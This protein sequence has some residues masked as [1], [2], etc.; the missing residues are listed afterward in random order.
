MRYDRLVAGFLIVAVAAAWS[1]LLPGRV[2]V[3]SADLSA[4]YK[5]KYSV[6]DAGP[7]DQ[8]SISA[9]ENG[10]VEVL[11]PFISG[12]CI[13]INDLQVQSVELG[14]AGVQIVN[15]LWNS[16][17]GAPCKGFMPMQLKANLEL[18]KPG[19]YMIQLW[20][21]DTVNA[22]KISRIGKQEVTV[23]DQ[24]ETLKKTCRAAAIT[25][26][27]LEM[28]RPQAGATRSALEADLE[29]YQNMEDAD[30]TLPE[31]IEETVWVE[32]KAGDNQILYVNGM[33]RSG[34]WY[35]LSGIVGGDYG[36][37]KPG[38]KYTATY[39]KVYPRAYWHMSSAYVCVTDLK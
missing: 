5:L 7:K 15:L 36:R 22:A 20:A 30:Y 34:P 16:D 18:P 24:Q 11:A 37:L 26:I 33:S 27:K 32:E 14:E 28:D 38:V 12:G 2:A 13:A 3:A 39:Y 10:R 9:D 4:D 6:V 35:H 8:F 29:K 1:F 31:K 21:T 19:K 25:A 17:R 23:K